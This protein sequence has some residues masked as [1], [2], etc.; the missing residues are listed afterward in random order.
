M[1]QYDKAWHTAKDNNTQWQE[2]GEVLKSN[3]IK[4][5]T[6]QSHRGVKGHD[7]AISQK[8]RQKGGKYISDYMD[9]QRKQLMSEREGRDALEAPRAGR[10]GR[11]SK[12]EAE[13]QEPGD[14]QVR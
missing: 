11:W 9:V 4:S 6:F 10:Q 12:A 1:K 8:P 14:L 5:H 13:Q 2:P 7:V 3:Y